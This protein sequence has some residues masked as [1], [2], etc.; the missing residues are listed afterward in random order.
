MN[1]TEL[2]QQLGIRFVSEGHH[3]CRPGWVQMDCPNCGHSSGKYHLGFN[4]GRGYFNC[5]VCGPKPTVETLCILSGQSASYIIG[6]LREALP[7]R[8]AKPLRPKGQLK[9][10]KGVSPLGKPHR[11]YLRSRGF[12]PDE[13]ATIWGV[14]GIG[15]SARLS[16]R[17]FIPIQY[18]YET[19]SWTTRAIGDVETRYISAAP[20]EESVYHKHLLYGADMAGH[21]IVVT[22]GPTDAWA[23]GPGAVATLGLG[24]TLEQLELIKAYPVR[25]VCFD[26]SPDA[27]RRARKL[28]DRLSLFLGETY[29]VNMSGKDPA[30][31]PKREV[32]ELRR[33][34]LD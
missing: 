13:I 9:V 28:T 12:D 29:L 20:E 18:R 25:A 6:L 27:Q 34:F 15:I 31:S 23:I 21:G 17:L 7:T 32:R 5:W 4:K 19:V 30:T 10:P 26:N 1:Y 3:H 11:K 33:R 24:Y 14:Q 16:W 22:E 2:L 8:E